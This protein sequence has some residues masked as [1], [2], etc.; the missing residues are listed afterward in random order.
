MVKNYLMVKNMKKK[1]LRKIVFFSFI[2]TTLMLSTILSPSKAVTIAP[3]DIFDAEFDTQVEVLMNTAKVE[4]LALCAIN[5]TEEYYSTGYGEQPGT[6]I[7]YYIS[8]ISGVVATTALLQLMDD[9]LFEMNDSVNDHLP[10]ILRNPYYPSIDITIH[11]CF[12][13]FSPYFC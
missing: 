6:D 7:V 1:H 5:G 9:G 8:M 10:W 4:S 2:L 12:S 11:G 3:T 13:P